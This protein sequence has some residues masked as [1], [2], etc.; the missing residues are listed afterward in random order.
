MF[1]ARANGDG[2]ANSGHQLIKRLCSEGCATTGR[3]DK[4]DGQRMRGVR[5]EDVLQRECEAHLFS[6]RLGT[7][8]HGE[9][10]FL[11]E[12]IAVSFMSTPRSYE[13]RF[14][15]VIV[16]IADGF[17]TWGRAQD[18]LKPCALFLSGF[19]KRKRG[20]SKKEEGK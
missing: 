20:I 19:V 3:Q 14:V 1:G 16:L 13:K 17:D 15:L 8:D 2:Q 4:D 6:S 11:F 12:G 18:K 7:E 5:A 10:V 9:P